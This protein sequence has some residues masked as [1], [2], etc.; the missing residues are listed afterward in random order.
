MSG[1]DRK[2]SALRAGFSLMEVIVAVSVIALLAGV[3]TPMIGNVVEDSRKATAAS[4]CQAIAN[5]IGQYQQDVGS[6]PPGVQN[7]ATYNY[8]NKALFGFGAEVL[9]TWLVEGSKK[10][11][12]KAIGNDPWG[13]PYNYNIYTRTDP[14]MDVTVYSNGP[15][16]TSE[17]WDQVLWNKGK[18]SGDDIGS[19]YDASK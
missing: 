14:N 13:T 10:Y 4:E 19:F 3:L 5:A 12:G 2:S 6:Y 18:L 17:S 8:G 9:N 16:K 1:H 11:L 15:N 7:D